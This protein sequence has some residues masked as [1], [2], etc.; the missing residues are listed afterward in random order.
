MPQATNHLLGL[1]L[2]DK[3]VG[4]ALASEQTKLSSPLVTLDNDPRLTQKLK[5]LIAEYSVETVVVGLPRTLSGQDS[6]QTAK[7]RQTIE[8]LTQDLKVQIVTQD[9]AL[10][11]VRAEEEL[12][13]RGKIFAKMDID[14]L[15]A[16]LIL[17][18]YLTS[19]KT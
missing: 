15:A 9:E 18:D 2:G 19:L 10:S 16:A 17:E 12:R 11:S 14:K 1:D 5:E 3:R 13:S 7:V 8:Q 4:V 6:T